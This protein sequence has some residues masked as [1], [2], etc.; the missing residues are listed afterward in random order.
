MKSILAWIGATVAPMTLDEYRRSW[1]RSRDVREPC[2]LCK[3]RHVWFNGVRRCK[4]VLLADGEAH[5]PG[6]VLKRRFKCMPC[7]FRWTGAT[8]GLSRRGVFQ[9]GVVAQAIAAVGYAAGSALDEIAQAAR[10]HKRTLSRWVGRLAAQVDPGLVARAVLR[11]SGEP[12][13]PALPET[14]RPTRSTA[15]GERNVRAAKSVL[16]LEVLAGLRGLDPPG[17]AHLDLLMPALVPT[18]GSGPGAACMA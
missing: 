2:P 1:E 7:G 8:A 3:S 16:L 11:E 6:E 5:A 12:A 14:V 13:L 10:C 15:V 9:P 17:L 4:P 18:A